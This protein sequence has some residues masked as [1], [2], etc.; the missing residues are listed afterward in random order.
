MTA[1]LVSVLCPRSPVVLGLTSLLLLVLSFSAVSGERLPVRS[2]TVGD[3]LLQDRVLKIKQD[4]RGFLWFCTAEGVS[5]F[6]GYGFTNLTTA[7]GLPDRHVNDFLET[8]NGTIYIATDKGLARLNPHGLRGSTQNPLFTVLLPD[9][10]KDKKILTLYETKKHQVWAG[11]SDGLYKLIEAGGRIAF[12]HVPLGDPVRPGFYEASPNTLSVN[13]ILED[14][15]GTLWVATFG[16]GLFR[17]SQDGSIR[18]FTN[19]DGFGDNKLTDLLEDRDGRLWVSLRSDELGGVCVLDPASEQPIR[20]CYRTKDGLSSNWIRAMIE[21]SDGQLWLAT[22]FGLCRWQGD[23][24]GPVCKTYTVK[25]DLCDDNLALAE[26]KDGNLWTGSACGAKKIARSGFVTYNEADGLDWNEINSIFENSADELFV[27]TLRAWRGVSRFDGAKFSL[28]KPHLPDYVDYVGWGWEQTVWQDSAGAWW[29]PTGYGLFRSPDNTSFENLARAPLEKQATGAKGL[30]VFRIFE[31]SRGD[32]WMLTTGEAHELLRWERAKNTWHNYT[33]Q[34]GFSGYRFGSAFVEDGNGNVWIG[35]SS[36]HGDSALIRYRD[37]EF[38]VLMQAAGAPSG[39]IADLFLDSRGR[40]WIASTNDGLWR[41]DEP[42]SDR[43][44]FIKYT[45]ANG[46]ASLN[47]AS[48]TEDQ[49]GRIYV[50]TWRGLDRL[51]PDTGQV[52]NFTT[53][54]GLPQSYVQIAYRDRKNNLWFGTEK[55]LVRFVP[56]PPRSRQ[57]PT[58]LITGLRVEGEPRSVS[59]LGQ[60]VIPS[61]ELSSDQKQVS[62]DFLGLGASLGEKL[63]YEYR[64]GKSEWTPTTERTINFANLNSGEYRF[65]VRTIT[66]DRLYSQSATMAFQILTPVWKRWW[67]IALTMV[68]AALAIYFFYRS[69]LSRLLQMER[70]RTRIAT[71]LHDDIGA[72]LTKIS[73]LSEVAKQK[74][75]S[76]DVDSDNPLSSIARIARESVTSM[77][78]IVWAISPRRDSL[79]DL[80]RHMREHAEEVF[81]LG[82]VSLSFGT[83]RVEQ[84]M[85]LGIDVRRDVFLIFKEAINNAARH[86]HCANVKILFSAAGAGLSLIVEDDGVGFASMAE[87][88]GQG[89]P[90]MRR[91]AQMMGGSLYV[92]SGDGRGTI[93]RLEVPF[94]RRGHH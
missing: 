8:K 94:S 42:N 68:L 66:I 73:I 25:N 32:I 92:E 14:R 11:T 58:I 13:T 4:S 50:G 89:L 22:N 29:I 23:G 87:D 16:S 77:G 81:A 12:E 57:P 55:G 48:V 71:D 78:D 19:V 1:S 27:S 46:L 7:D 63:K 31:D 44:E 86:G 28:V 34:V 85:K 84:N 20:K 33:A 61:L 59:V 83:P 49:F 18:R 74:F 3:G 52:E 75:G 36:D 56:E 79:L 53:A 88:E 26:D 21:T 17:L 41:L 9:N 70:V 62:V 30:E 64:L 10:P 45:P 24:G 76:S 15:H 5:R 54:D 37:G 65:E 93:V 35:A 6:D 90:S 72:N 69:R 38:R 80:V 40:L 67:F 51:N 82:D 47:T 43:F 2:Y 91:R 39:W 60:T